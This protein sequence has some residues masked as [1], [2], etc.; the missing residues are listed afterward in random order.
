[1]SGQ[2][3]AKNIRDLIEK[4]K[5]DL[6]DMRGLHDNRIYEINIRYDK[7]EDVFIITTD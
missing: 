1:M 3:G 4:V 2:Y 6:S 7:E 5:P